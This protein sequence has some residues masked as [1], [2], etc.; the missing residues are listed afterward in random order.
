[1]VELIRGGSLIIFV[2]FFV[3]LGDQVYDILLRF[4]GENNPVVS[5]SDSINFA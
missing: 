5:D 3:T 2:G 1:L 4:F